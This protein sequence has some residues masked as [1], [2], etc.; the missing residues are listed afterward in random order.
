[1]KQEIKPIASFFSTLPKPLADTPHALL[2]KARTQKLDAIIV[3][4]DDP[5]GTQTVKNVPVLTHWSIELLEKEL[6]NQTP[7]FFILTNSRSMSQED[8]KALAH[9]V[10]GHIL[11]AAQKTHK[12]VWVISRS[13]STLRGHYPAEVDALAA[14][15]QQ[16]QAIRIIIPAFFE[17]GRYTINNIHYVKQGGQVIPAAQT[18]YALDAVFG[19]QSSDLK[20]WVAE[21]TN[22]QIPAQEVA[23]FSLDEIRSG[24]ID[25]IIRQL[26][27]LEAGSTCIV[28]AANYADLQF[29]ALGLLQSNV[30]PIL[31][32]AA[33]FVAAISGNENPNLLPSKDLVTNNS[34]GGLVV[35]GSYV[36]TTN[37]QIE[38]L[39]DHYPRLI[40]VEMDVQKVL[41]SPNPKEM[42]QSLA[43]QID[44]GL[45]TGKTVVT[46]TSRHLLVAPSD[47]E[48]LNIGRVISS[49]LSDA[50]SRLEKQPA[51][52]IT[53]GGITSSVVATDSLGVQRATV[54][55][56]IIYGVPV[57]KL[58]PETKFPGLSQIIFPGNV[59]QTDSITQIV[60]DL[61]QHVS[62]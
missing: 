8:A 53:K 56:Q 10:G 55:G 54:L 22:H 18:P 62:L 6:E 39:F 47:E 58:G 48:N 11:A 12:K 16:K 14:G 44:E 41:N 46:Y 1:M 24:N 40:K 37:Q 57:L 33:S 51:F 34:H 15:M 19:Y 32:T 21:K 59:G 45:Q 43:Q 42:A 26:N 35:V 38:H 49:F 31:R 9:E 60:Q 2:Q 36:P 20:D 4:D 3:L 29:F 17:G 23:H 61:N 52:L 7:L 25:L 30:T 13:D 27:S 50:I 28:N 5:T